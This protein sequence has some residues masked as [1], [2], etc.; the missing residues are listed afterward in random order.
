MLG[1]PMLDL[2]ANPNIFNALVLSWLIVCLDFKTNFFKKF[3]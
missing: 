2:F 3:L 1:K